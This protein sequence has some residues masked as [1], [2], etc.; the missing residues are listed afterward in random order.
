MFGK[1]LEPFGWLPLAPI[2][3]TTKPFAARSRPFRTF[4]SRL[5]ELRSLGPLNRAPPNARRL[6]AGL[7]GAIHSTY[8]GKEELEP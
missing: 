3:F 6:K 2:R 4:L 7:R 1:G 8:Q 5:E